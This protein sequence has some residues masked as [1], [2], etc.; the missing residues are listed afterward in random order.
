MV[1]LADCFL[2]SRC[3]TGVSEKNQ[4]LFSSL[5]FSS[6]R[7]CT[8]CRPTNT[9]QSSELWK[10]PSGLSNTNSLTSRVDEKSRA[11]LRETLPIAAVFYAVFIENSE[12]V[13]P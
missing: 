12:G 1:S 8:R 5:A 2:A 7:V 6:L 11:F 10:K 13:V 4:R 9:N 3:T